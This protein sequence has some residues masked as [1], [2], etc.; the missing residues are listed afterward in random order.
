V[1]DR[2]LM[3]DEIITSDIFTLG[4]KFVDYRGAKLLTF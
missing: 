1:S 4:L 2:L 3:N